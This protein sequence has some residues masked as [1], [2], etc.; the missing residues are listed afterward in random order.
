VVA[1]G[2]L[3]GAKLQTSIYGTVEIPGI[4]TDTTLLSAEGPGPIAL[5]IQLGQFT[6][7]LL[8]PPAATAL[9]PTTTQDT[10][11]TFNLD[12]NP[13]VQQAAPPSA[14]KS[15]PSADSKAHNQGNILDAD[16]VTNS[17]SDSPKA[18]TNR[19]RLFGEKSGDQ[20]D[21][22]NSVKNVRDGVHDGIQGFR[23]GVRNVVKTVTG[24]GDDHN[25]DNSVAGGS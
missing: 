22:D 5:A 19:P 9:S 25:G 2:V 14:E 20:T 18:N 8:T 24:R 21:G 3:N 12:V 1:N 11:S 10:V 6:R 4:L 7:A 13:G 15:T 17:G 23:D 16:E